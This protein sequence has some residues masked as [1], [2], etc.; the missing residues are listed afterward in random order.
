M[1]PTIGSKYYQDNKEKIRAQQK[2]YRQEHKEKIKVRG[3]AYRQEHREEIKAYRQ[4]HREE[5]KAY[6]KAYYQE[7]KEEVKTYQQENKEKI[8]M[9][10][11][12]RRSTE[13]GFLTYLYTSC[14]SR[15]K[16]KQSKDPSK[17]WAL[18][19]REDFFTLWEEHKAKYGMT[20]GYGTGEPIIIQA[21]APKKNGKINTRPKNLLSIDRLDPDIGYTKENIV[22]C[23]W[24]FNRRKHDVKIKDCYLII[25]KH[26]ERNQ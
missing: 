3:K 4:E 2:A 10:I 8:A 1:A 22:F 14:K 21:T 20:C 25:R 18:L 23:G 9:Q 5:A 6:G 16:K 15:T 19:S 13:K 7:N 11:A 17:E 12:S 24:E 26:E